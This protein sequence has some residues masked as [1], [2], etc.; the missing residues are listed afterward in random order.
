[1]W[2]AGEIV[3]CKKMAIVGRNHQIAFIARERSHRGNIGVDESR[4]AAT[5]QLT[6]RTKSSRLD[7]FRSD[8]SSAIERPAPAAA[9]PAFR[10]GGGNG[11]VQTRSPAIRRD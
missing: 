8:L 9:W 1:M 10:L 3:E 11:P 6:I 2:Q 4:N 5:N 7:T